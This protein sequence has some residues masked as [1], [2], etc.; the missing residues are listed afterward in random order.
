MK[1]DRSDELEINIYNCC[2]IFD[3]FGNEFG[4]EFNW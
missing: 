1:S 2:F 4:S 3:V